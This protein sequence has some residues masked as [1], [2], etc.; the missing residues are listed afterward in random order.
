MVFLLLYLFSNLTIWL[1]LL[2]RV[3]TVL[4]GWMAKMMIF[5]SFVTI[6]TLSYLFCYPLRLRTDNPIPKP[7][8]DLHSCPFRVSKETI[9]P[10]N[11]TSH[12]L[13]S[14]YVDQRVSGF[15][16]RIIGIFQRAS[17][18]A[19]HCLFCC[20]G[21]KSPTTEGAIFQHSDNFGFPYVTTD[22]LCAIPEPCSA[23]HVTLLTDPS[24][25]RY[26][27]LTW[28]PI[29]NRETA[30]ERFNFTVCI[31]N[32]FGHYNNVLQ[33]AQSLEMYR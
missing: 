21:P 28:L 7:L 6:L 11:G 33:F 8:R 5:L 2:R 17:I 14:A 31:S 24:G 19:L 13:V 10:L 30:G 15:D 32:L 9:T 18:R 29:R 4:R 25:W 22:V 3:R 20:S 1:L 26:S 12:L 16:L 23:T 27:D